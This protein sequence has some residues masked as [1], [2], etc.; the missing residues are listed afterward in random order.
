MESG[1][2][3]VETGA[4]GAFDLL[5]SCLHF[6]TTR[7]FMHQPSTDSFPNQ[8]ECIFVHKV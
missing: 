1:T 2:V 6:A 8:H 4:E 7:N 3:R 5:L